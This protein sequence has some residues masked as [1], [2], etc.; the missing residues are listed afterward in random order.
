LWGDVWKTEWAEIKDPN[1][2]SDYYDP[3]NL[4]K[5]VQEYEDLAET[6]PLRVRARPW[7]TVAYYRNRFGEKNRARELYEKIVR[8]FPD[9][10]NVAEVRRNL[11]TLK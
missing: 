6:L 4:K 2:P 7:E 1:Q 5:M 9:Y 10:E 3:T 11:A 8:Q